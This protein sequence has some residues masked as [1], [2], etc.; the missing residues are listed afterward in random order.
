M[1]VKVILIGTP[2]IYHILHT[3]DEDFK[4]LFKV[5]VDFDVDMERNAE[6]MEKF[7]S[8]IGDICREQGLSHFCPCGVARVIDYSSRLAEDKHKLSTRFNEILEILYE[9]STWAE[10]DGSKTVDKEHVE[11]A[12]SEKTYRSN[13]IEERLLS[14]V[15]K[16]ELLIDTDGKAIG[17]I[18][19]LSV[20]NVGDYVFGQPSRITARTYMG[21]SGVVNIE[22]EAKLSGNI[23]NKAVMILTGYL[24]E[25]YARDIPLNISASI[26]F[27]QNYGGIEGD[28]ATCA[29]LIALL[30]SISGVPIRQDL[31]ITGSADQHGNVQPVG[32]TTYKIEGFY[33]VCKLGGLTGTQGVVIPHQ[34][35]TNLMLK[36]EVVWAVE[37]DKFHIYAIETIDDAIELMMGMDAKSF[38]EKTQ[39]ALVRI[40]QKSRKFINIKN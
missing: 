1:H 32:G 17:Q 24:G 3:Y 23:H 30:S 37:Q 2:H 22:R 39:A 19:G 38:H 25:K 35:I 29:E 11:K 31:A 8:F 15:M 13:R 10:I 12:I 40:A 20:L 16:G 36:P 6:N 5:K 4:K 14:K 26:A 7:A 28:S 21:S 27:E 33:H 9:S 18:N 34:N